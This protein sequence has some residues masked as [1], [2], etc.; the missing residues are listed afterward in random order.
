M[1]D[2]V[3]SLTFV[4]FCQTDGALDP[5][6]VHVQVPSVLVGT[7]KVG[8]VTTPVLGAAHAG[9][10]HVCR[11]DISV[12]GHVSHAHVAGQL[13]ALLHS[14][15]HPN[16]PPTHQVSAGNP[17]VA[18]LVEPN[19]CLAVHFWSCSCWFRFNFGHI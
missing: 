13:L 1:N 17:D 19:L 4:I 12:S 6:V 9:S 18:V 2:G 8:G 15:H 16:Q 10:I 5:E 7:G 11:Q 3:I 14:L